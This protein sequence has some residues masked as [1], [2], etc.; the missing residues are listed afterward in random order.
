MRWGDV[1]SLR[2]PWKLLGTFWE[3]L[4]ASG[5]HWETF[6]GPPRTCLPVC[7]SA[8]VYSSTSR[9]A[10]WSTS[11][12]V[13]RST[14]LPV[15]WSAGLYWS[16]CL[17]VCRGLPVYQSACL[18]VCRSTGLLVYRSGLLVYRLPVYQSTGVLVCQSTSLPDYWSASQRPRRR[19][20]L[21]LYLL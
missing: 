7:Q 1:W 2:E 13:Y 10:D 11:L 14:G 4:G 8:A 18:P 20:S 15:Y 9:A 12:P 3:R 21:R 19:I 16:T 17:L 6:V 5:N